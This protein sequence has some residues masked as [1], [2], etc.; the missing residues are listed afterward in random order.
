VGGSAA[1]T[2]EPGAWGLDNVRVTPAPRPSPGIPPVRALV[3]D[4]DGLIIDT[5]GPVYEAWAEVYRQHGQELSLDF[6]KTIVGR[7]SNYFDPIAELEKRL[8]R[9]LE[10]EAIRADRRLRTM[11]LVEALTILPGVLEWRED[12]RALGVGLGVA[13]S[14]G[15]GWVTGHLERL[16]LADWDCIRCLEDVDSPKPAADLYISV[17]ECLGVPPG[18]AVA[19]EDSV[20]GVQAAKTAGLYCVAVPSSLTADHDFSRADLV[21]TSLSDRSF[22]EVGALAGGDDRGLRLS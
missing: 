13:S 16:G 12:A 20:H 21:L 15:R 10:A 9:S 4:F 19:V 14:S 11:E 3:F 2:V 18:Q 22:A 17:L 6:W 7:G 5:E 1:G 8:G